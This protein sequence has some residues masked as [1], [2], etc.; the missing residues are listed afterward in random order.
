MAEQ[1]HQ[2]REAWLTAALWGFIDQHFTTAGY[3]VPSNIRVTCGFPAKHALARKMQRVGECWAS[4][5]SMDGTFEISVS[6]VMADPLKV[7][8]ILIHEVVHATVGLAAGH[9]SA[10]SQCASKV[11]LTSPWTATGETEDLKVEMA[12]WLKSLGTYHHAVL[13]LSAVTTIF[14]DDGN[15][16]VPINTNPPQSTRML[17]LQCHCGCKIRTTKK[18]IKLYGERWDCPCGGHLDSPGVIE[19]EA[20]RHRD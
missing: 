8:G 2:T 1:N 4:T 16:L 6:P 10:F 19:Q 9:R 5:Q 14:D 11:G 7:L 18:W 20:K 17:L 15:P 3:D 12:S 13:G